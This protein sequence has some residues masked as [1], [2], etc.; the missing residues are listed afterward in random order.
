MAVCA[1]LSL[2]M[3]MC[4]CHFQVCLKN[5]ICLCVCVCMCVCMRV[6]VCSHPK[7]SEGIRSDIKSRE[8]D[9]LEEEIE[10]ISFKNN[11]GQ[12]LVSNTLSQHHTTI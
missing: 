6:R 12:W 9:V 4:L 5:T 1:C 10:L 8:F 3:S 2:H 7:C 11:L